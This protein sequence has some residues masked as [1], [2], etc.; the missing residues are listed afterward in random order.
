MIVSTLLITWYAQG[1]Y[2]DDAIDLFFF[3]M[4]E[5]GFRPDQYTISIKQHVIGL[6]RAGISKVG[7]ATALSCT[8]AWSGC[9]NDN[10]GFAGYLG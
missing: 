4:L 10:L 2:A 8:Q 7:T 6:Y 1:G 3:Y 5:N 9:A